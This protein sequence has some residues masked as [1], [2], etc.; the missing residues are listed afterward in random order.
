MVAGG[1][2]DEIE[3]AE[4]PNQRVAA[5]AVASEASMTWA[6]TTATSS[7]VRSVVCGTGTP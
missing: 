7:G 1:P 6:D 5:M 2:Q 4:Q 3:R